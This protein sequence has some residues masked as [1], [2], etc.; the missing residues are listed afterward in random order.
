LFIFVHI[1]YFYFLSQATFI[2]GESSETNVLRLFNGSSTQEAAKQ[3]MCRWTLRM[4]ERRCGV[5]VFN[6]AVLFRPGFRK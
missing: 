2:S 6:E 3:A 5:T 4:I 1:S